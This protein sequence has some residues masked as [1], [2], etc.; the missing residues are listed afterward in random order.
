[1][2]EDRSYMRQSA[3]QPR[4]SASLVLVIANA[5]VYGL[6][7]ILD[8]P[9]GQSHN[10]LMRYCALRPGDLTHGWIWQL[11]TFQFLHGS[12]LHLILNCAMLWIFGR[13]IEDT[14]GKKTFLKLYFLSGII[15]GFAQVGCSWLFPAHFGYGS[16][17][18]A[19]AGIFGLIAAFAAL[20]WERP[21]TTLVAFIIPVTMKAKYLILVFGIIGILGLL[22][23]H[24]GYAHGAHLAGL[25][26]GLAYIR[27]LVQSEKSLFTWRRSRSA[28]ARRELVE[29]R[30]SRQAF[31]KRPVKNVPDD[32][33]P[34]EFI[35]KE[36][37]P[38]LDK[39]SAHGIQSLT[40]R[41]R[42]ILEAARAK[43][44]KR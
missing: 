8:L 3:Y 39:I 19:S 38:I 22:E 34:S 35:S 16:V 43:M 10:V 33:P 9:N 26:T 36:V 23:P 5:V 7:S 25:V 24:S 42:Q 13:P 27:F 1:M 31:W 32:L 44:G 29:A 18:G 2:L 4:W 11:L 12:P 21:I 41:E 40:L 30:S 14:L 37:D 15:G 17:V 20:N 6:Q 28:T